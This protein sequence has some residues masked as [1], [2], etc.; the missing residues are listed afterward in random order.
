MLDVVHFLFEED[1]R[2]ESSEQAEAIGKLRDVI[3]GSMYNTTYRYGYSGKASSSTGRKYIDDS[4][5]LDPL[6]DLPRPMVTKPYVPPTNF[7]PNSSMPFGDV[8]D[9]PLG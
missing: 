2:Y 8:L 6:D 1:S 3:Y 5:A 4:N 9:A 7:N